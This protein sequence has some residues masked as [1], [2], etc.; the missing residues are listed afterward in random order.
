MDHLNRQSFMD[1]ERER[2]FMDTNGNHLWMLIIGLRLLV[3]MIIPYS[4]SGFFFDDGHAP[5]SD[6]LRVALHVCTALKR[7]K[8]LLQQR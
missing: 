4:I 2:S 5:T 7:V 1:V 8:K 3:L 6:G